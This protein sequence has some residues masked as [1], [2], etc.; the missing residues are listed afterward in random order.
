MV[1]LRRKI[2]RPGGPPLIGTAHGVGY[3]LTDRAVNA[4]PALGPVLVDAA[5]RRAA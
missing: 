5:E 4:E 2:E 3:R 1:N